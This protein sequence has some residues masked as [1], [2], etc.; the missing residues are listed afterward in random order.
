MGRVKLARLL[1]VFQKVLT[2]A[3]PWSEP[4]SCSRFFRIRDP[5]F[6][7]RQFD[8]CEQPDIAVKKDFNMLTMARIHA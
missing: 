7:G 2:Q 3:P 1:S 5:V 8:E 6:R 4:P